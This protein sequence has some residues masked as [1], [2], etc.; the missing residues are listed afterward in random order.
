MNKSR[1][2]QALQRLEKQQELLQDVLLLLRKYAPLWYPKELD[3]RLAKSVGN[4]DRTKSEVINTPT[5]GTQPAKTKSLS[6]DL[7]KGLSE[8]EIHKIRIVA[9]KRTYEENQ[10][11]LRAEDSAANLFVVE[12]GC[13]DYFVPTNDGR[14][15]LLHRLMP[16]EAFGYAA[17]VTEPIGYLGTAK[18]VRKTETLIWERRVALQL[19]TAYPRFAEK[20]VH[21]SLRYIAL[22]AK[23][24]IRLVSNKA[25]E[26]V[27]YALTRLGSR[28]GHIVPAGV[29]V[30]VKNEDLASLAYVKFFTV[31]RIPGAWERQNVVSKSRGQILIRC[32]EKM[33]AA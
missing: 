6:V 1:S 23:R 33:L 30:A 20:A 32:P 13:V 31:S 15:L 14:E 22:Y 16:G 26:R 7:F 9:A 29:Q 18:A 2:K 11:I 21:A 5:S 8:H 10:T 12:T 25:Q 19:A 4:A 17:F 3:A 27:A 28:H 24:H